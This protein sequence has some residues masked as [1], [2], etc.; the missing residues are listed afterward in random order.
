[1][2]FFIQI[3]NL[4]FATNYISPILMDSV[5]FSRTSTF[6]KQKKYRNSEPQFRL[7]PKTSSEPEIMKSQK[8]NLT[9]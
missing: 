5:S 3:V 9:R 8:E 6:W 4:H 7:E 1:M 2:F